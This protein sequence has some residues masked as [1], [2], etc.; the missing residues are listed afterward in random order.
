[1]TTPIAVGLSAVI[2]A[3]DGKARFSLE[4]VQGVG[5]G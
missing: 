3:A 2:V 5:H 1:M 4:A